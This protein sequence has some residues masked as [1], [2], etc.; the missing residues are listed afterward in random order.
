MD[1]LDIFAATG[2]VD[3]KV[4]I[5]NSVSGTVRSIITMPR[6]ENRPNIFISQVKFLKTSLVGGS[7]SQYQ[8]T[9][10]LVI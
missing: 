4:C 10:L 8:V 6:R 3:N 9:I 2:G 1:H 7:D 5:W